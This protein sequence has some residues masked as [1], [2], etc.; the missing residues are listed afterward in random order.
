M[1]SYFNVFKM[2]SAE[3]EIQE[4]L[5]KNNLSQ[6]FENFID[7]GYDNMDQIFSM[8]S[9]PLELDSLMK[10]IAMFEKPGHE[11]RFV[12]AVQILASKAEHGKPILA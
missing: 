8:A 7:Q 6:Y 1:T 10:D 2:A 12:G 3:Y 11:K 4:F 9:N 5:K